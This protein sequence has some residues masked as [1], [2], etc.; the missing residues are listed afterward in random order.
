M[1]RL[2]FVLVSLALTLCQ[3]WAAERPAGPDE[4]YGQLFVDVQRASVFPDQKTF[5]DCVPRESAEKILAAYDAEKTRPGFDLKAFV[6]AH[7]LVPERKVVE[8][9]AGEPIERHVASLWALLRR[10]PDA[11]V[12]GSSLLPL[13]HPYIV[14]GGRFR[15][16]YYWDSYF[17]MLGLRESGD[18]A[19][20]ESMVENFA[21]LIGHYGYI[22]N[23]NRTYF[24]SRSQPPFF[25]LMIDVLAEKKGLGIY[26]KY[27]SALR[28]EYD[29]WMDGSAL[30]HHVVRM[31]DGAALNRYYDQRDTPRPEAF[32]KEEAVAAKSA[33]Q[34]TELYRNLRAA[35]ESGWDFS[36]RWFGDGRSLETIRTTQLV[37]VDL[38][39]LL[40][41]L[42]LTLS[43]AY[44]EAGDKENATH[45]EEAAER[46]KHALLRWCW[47][48]EDG[49][50]HDFDL[51]A[52]HTSPAQTL[53][54]V[55]PLF[56]HLAEPDQARRTKDMI[57]QKFL[58]PGGVVTTLVS[59]GQQWDAPNGWAPLQWLTIHGLEN[60][61]E[62]ELA[63]EIAHRWLELNRRVYARTGK[64]ME[65]YN[66]VDTSLEAGGGEY[67][68]Q[69][70]FGWTNGVFLK[71]S[72]DYGAK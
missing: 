41:H 4:I 19:M 46:R 70:G 33:E 39:C 63:S 58:R 59:T 55:M 7:F 32:A 51:E 37:P 56:F 20:I 72:R 6:A 66:V 21:Y 27:L 69:D 47:S 65:K 9:P 45:F 64:M 11:A 29:Y 2:S 62:H 36:S 18:E 17:T 13:P 5:V 54:G 30:T 49:Y 38:N 31:P 52:K 14:P 43:R 28:A 53:A 60:Y 23:G 24:L 68:S 16:I 15:E 26:S 71:L 35:A 42:E 12:P 1:K 61:G 34:K 40:Q 25:S 22:P 57:A 8:V 3:S 48:E 44:S 67:P 50:F 10:D